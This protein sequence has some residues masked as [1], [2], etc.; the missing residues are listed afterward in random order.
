M[1]CSDCSMQISSHATDC[2]H[3]GSSSPVPKE[4][5]KPPQCMECKAPLSHQEELCPKCGYPNERVFHLLEPF[6][7]LVVP[8]FGQ[9]KQGRHFIGVAFLAMAI[10]GWLFGLGW[11]FHIWSAFDAFRYRNPGGT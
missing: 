11:I 4:V 3:C 2:P 7:S 9:H 8:G 5:E 10:V 6:A 1:P